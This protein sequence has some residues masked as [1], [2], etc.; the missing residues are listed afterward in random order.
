VSVVGNQ[1]SGQARQG[2]SVRDG[3]IGATVTG[4]TVESTPTGIY[5]RDSTG[6]VRGNTVDR[7]TSHGVTLVGAVKGTE[8]A[9]NT[10]SGTGPTALDT[11]RADGKIVL[12]RNQTAAWHDTRSLWLKIRQAAKP[13]TLLWLGVVL[14]VL[15]SA[16]R[17][18]KLGARGTIVHPY[19]KQRLLAIERGDVLVPGGATRAPADWEPP[20]DRAAGGD[21]DPSGERAGSGDWDHSG[22]DQRTDLIPV[23]AGRTGHA[24]APGPDRH[25]AAPARE[26]H[27]A[28]GTLQPTDGAG[29]GTQWPPAGAALQPAGGS[30]PDLQALGGWG[31]ERQ[32]VG[33]GGRRRHAA[34]LVPE[35]FPA[36]EPAGPRTGGPTRA[37]ARRAR[38]GGGGSPPP[39]GGGPERSVAAEPAG[40]R[41]GEAVQNGRTGEAVQNGRTGEAVQDG[42]GRPQV[43]RPGGALPAPGAAPDLVIGGGAARTPAPAYEE[44]ATTVLPRPRTSPQNGAWPSH[45]RPG[46]TQDRP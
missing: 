21:R 14:L 30:G 10:I 16:F 40:P 26:R 27:S 9:Y 17:A 28:G 38:H 8:V 13:M 43:A 5:L 12:Q 4:N 36:A 45:R 11:A 2:I 42:G 33:G 31:A 15:F 25:T 29:L 18:R 46:G 6:T 41:T 23:G 44:D 34:A 24:A 7:V 35:R 37:E 1:V 20:G 22:V 32:A 3:V 39:V 19:E